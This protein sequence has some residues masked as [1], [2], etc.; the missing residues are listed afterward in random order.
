MGGTRAALLFAGRFRALSF[1]STYAVLVAQ[2][3][4]SA[5]KHL[6]FRKIPGILVSSLS[7][8]IW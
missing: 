6:L 1:A 2:I 4:A 5:D 7:L 3:F 8:L